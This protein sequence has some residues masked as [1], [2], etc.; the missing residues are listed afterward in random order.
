MRGRDLERW[1]W[2][3]EMRSGWGATLAKEL[4]AGTLIDLGPAGASETTN[5]PKVG[6]DPRPGPTGQLTL[7]G[8]TE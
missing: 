3:A 6:R 2:L 4:R 7:D 8:R 5:R 1:P